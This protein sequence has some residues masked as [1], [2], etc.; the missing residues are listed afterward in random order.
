[1]VQA[2]VS[3][4]S[5]PGTAHPV[6]QL[7]VDRDP[8]PGV[9]DVATPPRGHALPQAEEPLLPYNTQCRP[10]QTAPLNSMTAAGSLT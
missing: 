2:E 7:V 8:D 5:S 3:A 10:E 6:P 4:S 9:N 1:M